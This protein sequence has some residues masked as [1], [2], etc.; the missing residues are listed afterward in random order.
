MVAGVAAGLG[1]DVDRATG[2]ASKRFPLLL[3]ASQ[4]NPLLSLF[5]LILFPPAPFSVVATIS[6]ISY[7]VALDTVAG[8]TVGLVTVAGSSLGPNMI[9]AAAGA[10]EVLQLGGDWSPISTMDLVCKVS[11]GDSLLCEASG[12][13]FEE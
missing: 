12:V 9:I 11:R 1:E 2:A 5:P 10:G 7:I 13:A 6:G 4:S 3:S 8:K